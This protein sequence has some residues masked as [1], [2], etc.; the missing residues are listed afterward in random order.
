MFSK[1]NLKILFVVSISALLSLPYFVSAVS[2]GE[3][4]DFFV[5]S[6]YDLTQREEISA[7]LQTIGPNL[8]F[9]VDDGW[10]K[11]L[12]YQKKQEVGRAFSSLGSEFYYQIYP[13]LTSTFGYEWKP[14]IDEDN[15]IAVLIHPMKEGAGGYFNKF[16]SK[17]KGSAHSI[18]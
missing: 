7:I 9:Y 8:Y 16:F 13:T 12:E 14:G 4:T 6:T 3:K 11:T 10:W 17:I 18:V 5:D 15:R 2:L 1:I